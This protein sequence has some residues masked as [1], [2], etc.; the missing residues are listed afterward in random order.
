MAS[1]GNNV[2]VVASLTPTCTA[3]YFIHAFRQLG[4]A[5]K[6]CSDVANSSANLRVSGAVDVSS[7]VDRLEFEPDIV[8]FIEG[9][10]MQILPVGLERLTC[11]TAWY[12]IDTHMNYAKHLRIGRL[13]DVNFIAQKE[14]VECLRADGLRQVHWLPLGF[15]PEL[16]PSPMPERTIDIAYVGSDRVTANPERHALLRALRRE[17]SSTKFGA[18]TPSEMGR[19]YASARVVF[20]KSVKNDVNMRFFE[21]AGAGAVLVTDPI[22][23]NGVE[24][25][26]EEGAHYVSYRDEVSLIRTVRA[27]LADPVRCAA[28]G[29]CARQHVLGH[30][31]YRHRAERFLAVLEQSQKLR[32][33]YPEDYFAACLSLDLLSGA[34]V[35]VARAVVATKAGVYRRCAGYAV[36]WML[37][38]LAVVLGIA[39]RMRSVRGNF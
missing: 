5:V 21:A 2:L 38:V 29:A 12:G 26:F 36:A 3:H 19:I 10:T 6:A 14:Y 13:F 34:V 9:G 1:A 31:T 4:C 39:E 30:H 7:V 28:M 27:V 35:A 11:L 22:V 25:L 15:A 16:L 18:A 24:E 32:A 8:L 37:G 23:G 17:F 33:P 20:N